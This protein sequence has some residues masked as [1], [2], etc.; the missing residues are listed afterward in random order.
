MTTKG[1]TEG[2]KYLK[3]ECMQN[4]KRRLG[5]WDSHSTHDS[6]YQR[7]RNPKQVRMQTEAEAENN[8]RSRLQSSV[9]II[10]IIESDKQQNIPQI[11]VVSILM[12]Y[13][14]ENRD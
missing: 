11:Y 13:R 8:F 1:V 9:G 4:Q 2:I 14:Q 3:C 5:S 7:N 10:S 12:L 6:L